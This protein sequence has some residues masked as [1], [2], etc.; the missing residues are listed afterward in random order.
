MSSVFR[1]RPDEAVIV[2][3]PHCIDSRESSEVVTVQGVHCETVDISAEKNSIYRFFETNFGSSE[4]KKN[5]EK[6]MHE[7]ERPVQIV[8]LDTKEAAGDFDICREYSYSADEDDRNN[9]VGVYGGSPT[10]VVDE[11]AASAN[12]QQTYILGRTYHPVHGY[13]TRRDDESSLFWFTYRCDFPDIAPYNI[14][15]DAG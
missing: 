9:G 2:T 15:S 4:S 3:A 12:V 10:Q 13:N 7:M 8:S 14:T 1:S 5:M 6:E 11:S